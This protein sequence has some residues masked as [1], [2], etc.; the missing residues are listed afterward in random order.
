MWKSMVELDR[1]QMT[2]RRML[3][4]CWI[5]KATDTQSKYVT[6]SFSTATMVTRTHLN[7]TLYVHCL[8]LVCLLFCDWFSVT[9]PYG[10]HTE[11]MNYFSVAL[12]AADM[13]FAHVGRHLTDDL[14]HIFVLCLGMQLRVSEMCVI[15]KNDWSILKLYHTSVIGNCVK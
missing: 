2:I 4:A 5:I 15:E 11:M 8:V 9:L 1:P 10:F 7:V 13:F 3:F 12:I 6:H 14:N